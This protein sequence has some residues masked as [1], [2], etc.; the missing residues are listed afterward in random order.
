MIPQSAGYNPLTKCDTP[1]KQNL[2]IHIQNQPIPPTLNTPHMC[3]Q[4]Q[5]IQ[6]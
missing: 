5:Q 3:P 6:C 4:S 2:G 1:P